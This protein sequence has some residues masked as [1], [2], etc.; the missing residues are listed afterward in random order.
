MSQLESTALEYSGH[1]VRLLQSL[2]FW[3]FLIS[4]FR[5]AWRSGRTGIQQRV[6][7]VIGKGALLSAALNFAALKFDAWLRV[8][9]VTT[10]SVNSIHDAAIS[11]GTGVA[12]AF[13][14]VVCYGMVWVFGRLFRPSTMSRPMA[15]TIIGPGNVVY[16]YRSPTG[17]EIG[18]VSKD[19]MRELRAAGETNDR[20]LVLRIEKE[21]T[22]QPQ[23]QFPELK[24][25]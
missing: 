18:P 8:P 25:D 23:S 19:R 3:I 4:I 24:L 17:L 9:A 20:T 5:L 16:K 2:I 14:Y 22:W 13:I 12:V 11:V 21:A 7:V 15:E 6:N 10:N 1:P